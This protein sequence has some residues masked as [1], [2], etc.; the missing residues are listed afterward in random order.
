MYLVVEENPNCSPDERRFSTLGSPRT[1]THLQIDGP[2]GNRGWWGATG[3]DEGGAFVPAQAILMEDSGAGNVWLIYGGSWGL[4]FRKEESSD[5]SLADKSQWGEPFK[6]LDIS[7]EDIRFA[8][9]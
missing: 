9:Q 8:Q 3:V 7:G 2:N 4:R 1:V 5:W 6:V